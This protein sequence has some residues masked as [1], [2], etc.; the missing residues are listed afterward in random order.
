MDRKG[1]SGSFGLLVLLARLLL[2]NK[3]ARGI[4]LTLIYFTF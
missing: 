2:A 1:I 3:N 4:L